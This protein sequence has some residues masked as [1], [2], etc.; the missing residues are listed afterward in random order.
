MANICVT[1]TLC[2][3]QYVFTNYQ[4]NCSL[5][6]PLDSIPQKDQCLWT[7]LHSSCLPP[8]TID[9]VLILH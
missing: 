1:Q 8:Y 3:I 5:Y 2:F 6:Y 9:Q 7:T 4:A